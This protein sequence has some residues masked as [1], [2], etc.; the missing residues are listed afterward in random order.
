MPFMLK[1][2]V[3]RNLHIHPLLAACLLVGALLVL[4]PAHADVYV[5]NFN[6]PRA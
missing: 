2:T 4:P 1:F 3:T 6:A 5:P